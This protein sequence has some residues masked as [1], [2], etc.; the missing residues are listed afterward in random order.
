MVATGH[1]QITQHPQ[2]KAEAKEECTRLWPHQLMEWDMAT[3]IV[4]HIRCLKTPT[5]TTALVARYLVL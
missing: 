1:I 4:T 2:R 5:P 3:S